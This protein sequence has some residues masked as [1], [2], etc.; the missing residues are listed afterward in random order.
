MEIMR[1]WRNGVTTRQNWVHESIILE[2]VVVAKRGHQWSKSQLLWQISWICW[3]HLP[4]F[5]LGYIGFALIGK[6][7]MCGPLFYQKV[8]VQVGEEEYLHLVSLLTSSGASLT[9]HIF[10][11]CW[12]LLS[13]KLIH[14]FFIVEGKSSKEGNVLCLTSSP[15]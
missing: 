8:W 11:I 1:W 4:L 5:R 10:G 15:R 3:G 7:R 13:L 2:W 9:V 14:F 12:T 6:W